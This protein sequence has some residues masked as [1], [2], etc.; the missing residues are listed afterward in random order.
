MEVPLTHGMVAIIDP[1]DWPLVSRYSWSANRSKKKFYAMTKVRR[2][3][4]RESVFM[5][6]LILGLAKGE[7]TDHVNGDSLDNRRKNLRVATAFQNAWNRRKPQRASKTSQ[8]KGVFFDKGKFRASILHEGKRH[9]LGAFLAEE[10]AARAYDAA[11]LRLRGEWAVLN[12]PAS[13]CT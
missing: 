3:G 9:C 10:A 12:F 7:T 8:Y 1:E 2:G 6:R 5:H 11:C 4:K 13:F